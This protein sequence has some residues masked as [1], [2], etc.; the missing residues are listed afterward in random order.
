M[1][2]EPGSTL[3]EFDLIAKYFAPLAGPEGLGLKD[4]AALFT[5]KPGTQLVIT[6]D[7]MTAGVHF[8]GDEQPDV[9]AQRLLRVNLSDLSGKGA[10]PCGYL[11]S[12]ALPGTVDGSWLKAFASGLKADQ[13]QFGIVLFGGDTVSTPGPLVLSITAF[14]EVSQDAMIRRGGADAGDDLYVTGTIGDAAFGLE[15]ARGGFLELPA[16]QRA[17]LECRYRLPQPRLAFGLALAEANIASAAADV[18]DGLLADAGHVAIASCLD[19]DVFAD[20]APISPAAAEII[21]GDGRLLQAL[22]GGDDYEIVFAAKPSQR[23]AL[24]ALA[25]QQ[26]LQVSRIGA[27][28]A[29]AGAQ[30]EV[31]LLGADGAPMNI[32]RLGYSHR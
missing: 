16:K 5:P 32:D 6:A 19:V 29:I 11:L 28:R 14:G 4:D 12:L 21:A 2:S 24:S 3:G 18:S 13:E 31:R 22:T 20:R 17:Y 8:L 10:R 9:I 1:S 15:V 25:E 23:D 27:F 26:S 7:A 30:S